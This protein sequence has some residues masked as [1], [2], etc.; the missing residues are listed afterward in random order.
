MMASW[1]L[2][3]VYDDEVS[4]ADSERKTR[5]FVGALTEKM[6]EIARRNF[7]DVVGMPNGDVMVYGNIHGGK[8]IDW[9]VE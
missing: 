2:R 3:G 7:I 4:A 9:R 6:L 1:R 5:P 8:R